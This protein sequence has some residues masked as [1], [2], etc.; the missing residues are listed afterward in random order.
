MHK[1]NKKNY[2]LLNIFKKYTKLTRGINVNLTTQQKKI[3][4]VFQH[5]LL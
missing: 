2:Y 3:R 1:S 5:P 4:G